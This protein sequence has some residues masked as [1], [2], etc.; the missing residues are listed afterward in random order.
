MKTKDDRYTYRVTWSEEDDEY[1]GLCTEFPSL[2]WL[3][4]DPEAA[5][6]GIRKLVREVIEDMM[7][8]GEAIPDPISLKRYSG[9]FVVR[10]PPQVHKKL[11]IEAAESGVSLNRLASSKLSR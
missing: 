1:V 4:K 11:A 7:K 6:R 10:V 3:A 8:E 5:L 2:S 9:R